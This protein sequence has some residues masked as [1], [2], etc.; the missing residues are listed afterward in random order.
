MCTHFAHKY[1]ERTD[2]LVLI[3]STGLMRERFVMNFP[4]LWFFMRNIL[5]ITV[6]RSEKFLCNSARTSFFD[7]ASRP[8]DLCKSFY[9]QLCLP[10]H[11][12]AW[13][14]C[15]RNAFTGADQLRA[16]L[17][18]IAVPTQIIWGNDDKTVSPACGEEFH[19]LIPGSSLVVFPECAHSV[20]LEKAKEV[21]AMLALSTSNDPLS[22]LSPGFSPS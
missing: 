18:Q 1:P 15:M 16:M 20:P 6:M 2:R 13:L 11:R 10:G 21:V 19:K 4:P 3:C 12:R 9:E 7:I 5:E 17:P 14:N 22:R 8:A